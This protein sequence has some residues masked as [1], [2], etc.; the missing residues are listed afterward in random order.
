MKGLIACRRTHYNDNGQVDVASVPECRP[1]ITNWTSG[2]S[3][4]THRRVSFQ[5]ELFCDAAAAAVTRLAPGFL[6]DGFFLKNIFC[7]YGNFGAFNEKYRDL[8]FLRN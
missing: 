2:D 8:Y 4:A 6:R 5:L 1:Q 3:I 7:A